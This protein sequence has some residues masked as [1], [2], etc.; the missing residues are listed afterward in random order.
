MFTIPNAADA[1]DPNQAEPD[2]VDI[3]ILV[4][5]ISG[6]GVVSGCAVSAVSGAGLDVQVASGEISVAG[7][8][9]PVDGGTLVLD[10]G[11]TNPR[12]DLIVALDDTGVGAEVVQGQSAAEP[13]FP[14]IPAGAVALAAVFVPAGATEIDDVHIVDK[15]CFVREPVQSISGKNAIIGGDF[16]TNPWQRGTTFTNPT[17]G[18]YTADRWVISRSDD[19][20][21]D[22][23]KTAFTTNFTLSKGVNTEHCLHL[24]V[25][26]ADASIGA[27]QF[28]FIGQR[29]EGINAARFG[30]GKAGT[31]Y[32]TL[33]FLHQHTKTGTYCVSFRNSAA[34][35]SYI[36]EYTQDVSDAVELA[37]I[38][39]PVDTSGTWLYGRAEIGLRVDFAVAVGTDKQTA[40]GVWTA[41]NYSS[42]ANQVNAL[43]STSNNFKIA[44]VQLEP[45]QQATEFETLLAQQVLSLCQRHYW[46]LP[47]GATNAFILP[48]GMQSVANALCLVFFP[49]EMSATPTLSAAGAASDYYVIVNNTTVSCTALPTVVGMH[50]PKGMSLSFAATATV[51]FASWGAAANSTAKLSFSAEL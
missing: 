36:A 34:N 18:A 26:T 48:G 24:D 40:A 7:V 27:S 43:D 15:R 35:R 39:V 38:T 11:E 32:I 28:Y 9:Y 19:A 16:T 5:G 14:A 13:V 2:K 17:N 23:L 33:A 20:A 51:G 1:A 50:S 47:S 44:L 25:T 45:E 49:V 42:S 30:F 22:V 8:K 31:R 46:E 37:V 41:G 10:A 21:V 4:A 12:F 3:D 29:I 6:D